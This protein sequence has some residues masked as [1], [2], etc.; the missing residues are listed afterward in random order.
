MTV[1]STASGSRGAAL[2]VVLWALV[3]LAALAS[4]AALAARLDLALSAGHRDH[5]AALAA[6]EAGLADV[7]ATIAA[8]PARALQSDSAS[9]AVASGSYEV[10]WEPA[11]G[12]IR[13]L[14]MGQRGSARRGVEVWVSPDAEGALQIAAWRETW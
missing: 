2:A 7:L 1:A 5:A 11:G 10:R 14:A 4:S 8:D 9:G 12:R 3:A 13:L 6:A